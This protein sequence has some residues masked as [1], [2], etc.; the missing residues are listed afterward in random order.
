VLFSGF[1]IIGN[2]INTGP[3]FLA[4]WN[5]AQHLEWWAGRYQYSSMT[6]QLFW[7]PNHALGGWLMVGLILRH[8]RFS[9][10]DAMLPLLVVAAALWSPL[11]ALGVV[12]FVLWR[13]W[14]RLIG[15]RRWR[16]LHPRVWLP[17]LCVGVI[18][19]SYLVLDPGGIAK[20]VSTGT[21]GALD[22]VFDLLNQTQFFLL[23]AGFIGFAILWICPTREVVHALLVLALLPLAYLGPANDLVMRGSIP[24][25]AVLALGACVALS[26]QGEDATL[27]RKKLV[28]LFLLAVGAVTPLQEFAR[29]VLLPA[30]PINLDA[31][32]IGANCGTYP[33]HYVAR[34]SDQ[35]I[36]HVLRVPRRVALDPASRRSCDNPAIDLMLQR[37]LL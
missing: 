1:D 25:L 36:R 15:E 2:I 21:G 8:P 4:N 14:Q 7:V 26:K 34:L 24:A 9:A 31:T 5:I 32:L 22:T 19:A 35:A 37:N 28:L 18:V 11:S 33:P 27:L 16:L 23:E 29:S 17:A 3:R 6:T 30:W 10:L 13:A 12:P 20:G